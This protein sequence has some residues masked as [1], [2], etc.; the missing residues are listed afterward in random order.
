M[1]ITQRPFFRSARG[2]S[3]ADYDAWTL[4]F[5]SAA[6]RLLVRHLWETSRHSGYDDW[7]IAEFLADEEGA[8]QAALFEILFGRVPART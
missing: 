6:K 5:D 8:P 3:P 1:A 4:V 7:D 2:P